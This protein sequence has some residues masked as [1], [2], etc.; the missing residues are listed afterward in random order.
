MKPARVLAGIY[1]GGLAGLGIWAAVSPETFWPTARKTRKRTEEA[2]GL[3]LPRPDV[4]LT[5][6]SAEDDFDGVDVAICEAALEVRAEQPGLELADPTTFVEQSAS[7]A[8]AK[9]FP[10]FPWP[11]I[12]G[13]D[14]TAAE[15][16]GLVRYEIRRSLLEGTLCLPEDEPDLEDDEVEDDEDE[17]TFIPPPGG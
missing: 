10:D 1:L 16:Q 11:A 3:R 4:R 7:R 17:N 8:L 15:I 9:L 2:T 14:P 6:P 12:A 13:D 5:T